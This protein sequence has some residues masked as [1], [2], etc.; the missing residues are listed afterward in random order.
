MVG[1]SDIPDWNFVSAYGTTE[2]KGKAHFTEAPS[3]DHLNFF[4]E[5]SPISHIHK[6][7]APTLFLL[8]AKDLR[9]P[10]PDGLQY[11]RA[12]KARGVEVKVMMFPD[13]V[14][15]ISRPQSEFE[16]FLNIGMWFKKHC[17]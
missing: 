17:P 11:A 9:V 4:Y 16:S 6:V 14:H 15:E 3:K 10:V 8:G 12:L 1:T 2:G 7:K 13:D 5:K